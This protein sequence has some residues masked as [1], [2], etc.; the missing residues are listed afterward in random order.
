MRIAPTCRVLL[1]VTL[2]LLV[3]S[4]AEADPPGCETLPAWSEPE[5]LGP[6]VNSSFDELAATLSPDG[7]SLYFSSNRPGGTSGTGIWVSQRACADCPWGDPVDL[8]VINSG[9]GAGQPALSTDGRLLFF[10]SGRPGGQGGSDIWVSHRAD[11][12]D[13]FSWQAPVN[14]GPD[15]N[16]AG[17]EAGA[18]YVKKADVYVRSMGH[19]PANARAIYFGRGSGPNPGA[20]QDIYTAPVTRDGET[21]GPAILVDELNSGTNDAVPTVRTDGREIL[22]WS[23]REG[24]FGSGDIWVSTRRNVRERWSL[25]ENVGPPVNTPSFDA[26][27]SLSRG[28]R[29]LLFISNRPGSFV[30]PTTGLPSQ[31]I[32]MSTRTPGCGDE[33]DD[34]DE[35]NDDD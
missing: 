13:D 28:G 4:Q 18:H 30:N 7:L 25:P 33:D 34:H 3:A 14:L 15:V 22:F 2:G 24:G 5:N 19:V 23:L 12:S 20:N 16:T 11:P 29:T 26:R 8:T 27:P 32:W 17:F 10:S 9:G 31:D 21:L 6:P 35:E 1:L